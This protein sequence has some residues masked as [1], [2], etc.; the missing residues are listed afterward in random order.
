M[1]SKSFL[2]VVLV[3]TSTQNT[4]QNLYSST[5]VAAAVHIHLFEYLRGAH[6]VRHVEAD[7]ALALSTHASHHDPR[8][9]CASIAPQAVLDL[10]DHLGDQ[11][12]SASKLGVNYAAD[13]PVCIAPDAGATAA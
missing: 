9:F 5:L 3:L 1:A 2:A 8:L 6:P 4:P 12:L 11:G 10:V 13:G 7:L